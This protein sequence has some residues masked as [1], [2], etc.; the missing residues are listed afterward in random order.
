MEF[1]KLSNE[2]VL[3]RF[4][5]FPNGLDENQIQNAHNTFGNNVLKSAHTRRL[6]RILFE[7]FANSLVL[8]L[9]AA[10]IASFYLGQPRDGLILLIIVIMNALIGFYQEWKSEN[11]LASIRKLVVDKC[12][13]IRSGKIIEIYATDLV[14]GDLVI[15]SEGVGIPADI[16][17]IESNGFSI[18]EFI[19]TGES[20]PAS[21][22]HLFQTQQT[23]PI[24]E[25]KNSVYMGTTVARGEA[26]GIVYAT[27]MQTE[28]G[29][30][31]SSSQK[32]KSTDAPIQTE[33][34][35]VAK[36]L[37]FV[38]FTI[39]IFLFGTRLLLNDSIGVAL[40][41]SISIAASMV[42]E[43]LPA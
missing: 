39:G 32:I 19:L 5:S 13:V 11:I 37:T 8:I 6:Y 43:G 12:T 16:R 35:D 29:R 31:S 28:I 4:K 41:F 2:E 21:K 26:K 7:Q 18:N 27:G 10:S 24:N 25:V 15:L 17:L 22:D 30:I 42:P 33:I 14:P 3:N 38:T 40:V 36:K 1:Y 34:R 9:I 20:L 23:I